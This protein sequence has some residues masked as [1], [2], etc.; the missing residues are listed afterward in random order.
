MNPENF[1]RMLGL[2]AQAREYPPA[3]QAPFLARACPE[4]EA[5]RQEVASL[6]QAHQAAPAFLDAPAFQDGLDL[7]NTTVTGGELPPGTEL[8][9]YR[10][11]SLLGEGGMG[12]VYLAE[13]TKLERKVAVKLLKRRLDDASLARR[14][15]HERRVLAA[16]THPNIA[17]LY[18]GGSTPEGRSYLVMEYVEGE[19]L[20]RYCQDHALD[21]TAR[22]TLFRKVC[23]AVSYAHQNLVVHRD[24]KPANIRVTPECEPKLL[25]FGIAKLLDPE[26][27]TTRLEPT[28]TMQGAMTPEYASPEQIK[29]EPITT[30]SDVYS[31]GVVLFELLTGQRPYAHLQSR[32]PDE[33]ARAIC[34]E[35]PP[36]V[37]TVATHPV[38]TTITAT[39]PAGQVPVSR[40]PATKLRRRLEGDLDNIVAKALRKE[41]GRR[42]PSVLALSEDIRR[43][44]EGLPV[45]ARKDTLRYRAGKFVRRNKVGVTAAV[46]VVLALV[47]GLVAAIWQARLA[48]QERDRA[49]V[50]LV[51]A[52]TAERQ[53]EHVND[54]L[55]SLLAG[56]GPAKLGKDVRVVQ[57]VDAAATHLD[58]DLA[59]EPEVLVQAHL[60][61][62]R[63]YDNLGLYEPAEQQ[64]RAALALVRQL[65]GTEVLI[66][67]DVETLLGN[68]LADR[69]KY[70]E[71]EPLLR[72]ALA[73]RRAQVPPDRAALAK[74][75]ST[76]GFT[77]YDQP[78]RS[79]EAEALVNEALGNARAVWGEH[80]IGYLRVLNIYGSVKVGAQDYVGAAVIFRQVLS[81]LDQIMPGSPNTLVPQMNLCTCLFNAEKFDELELV[82]NRL[83][84][85]IERLVGESNHHFA[86]ASLLHG[87]MDM[88]R[89]ENRAALPYLQRA[90]EPS[91]ANYPPDGLNVVQPQAALGLCLTRDGR[92]AEGEK[93]LRAA[94]EHGGKVNRAEFAHTFGNLE[95]ALGECL[96]AQ[97]H[98]AEAEPLLLTGCDDLKKRLGPQNRFTIQA[99]RRLHDLYLAWNKPAEAARFANTATA[100]PSRTP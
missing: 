84:A 34:E 28:V 97:Q 33:L 93:L 15:R 25:D 60:T 19:R 77:L 49:Q 12:E 57:V 74:S 26:G 62:G 52:K 94:Y 1:E 8:G 17:R 64:L 98:Y 61:L 37:S 22:L 73:V 83:D 65:H 47:T 5:I 76:L 6:L 75:L 81:L 88:A 80:D 24:L 43:H 71:A 11:L 55:Q 50:A 54:F 27:T 20:D 3:E 13:D 29:G 67:A 72:H 10:I 58:H 51:Q 69:T 23:A 44:C 59:N 36:R 41:P 89:G 30:A 39:V 91:M 63:T 90:L 7:L 79:A 32:R 86:Q 9:E 87:L 78:G 40:E 92:A 35:E 56:G 31:L 2:F 85:D 14:F 21:V 16:L 38:A 45:T 82:L 99:T 42:Y 95:T 100:K 70:A 68:L 66:T 53:A 96:L 4:D 18:G 48:R 46:L